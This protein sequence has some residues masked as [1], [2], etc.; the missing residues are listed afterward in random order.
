M[1]QWW[2]RRSRSEREESEGRKGFPVPMPHIQHV[3]FHSILRLK[4]H[5]LWFQALSAGSTRPIWVPPRSSR[6]ACSHFPP[7]SW[8]TP[9]VFL[10]THRVPQGAHTRQL[11]Q[12]SQHS[13]KRPARRWLSIS[14][15]RRRKGRHREVRPLS[16]TTGS[17]VRLLGSDPGS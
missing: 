7:S 11:V 2:E 3:K 16:R 4:N 5:P 12:F 1:G 8:P 10:R 6:M 14:I 9:A 13:P 15:P 17:S